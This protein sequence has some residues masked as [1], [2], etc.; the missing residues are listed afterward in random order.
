MVRTCQLLLASG[1]VVRRTAGRNTDEFPVG[2]SAALIGGFVVF[3]EKGMRYPDEAA[4]G[5]KHAK[6]K[7][8]LNPRETVPRRETPCLTDP[9]GV[10]SAST[11]MASAEPETVW[12]I[13]S[14]PARY[15]E[16]SQ[17]SKIDRVGVS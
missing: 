14:V 7:I 2:L 8:G 16:I 1:N 11:A 15:S 9:I 17:S 6:R 12:A 4:I 5:W 13:L 10:P 3:Q